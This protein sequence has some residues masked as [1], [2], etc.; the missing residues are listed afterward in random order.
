VKSGDAVFVLEGEGRIWG[1]SGV[2]AGDEVEVDG[3]GGAADE[4]KVV[5]VL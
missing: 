3:V 1:S 4:G 5:A 2:E